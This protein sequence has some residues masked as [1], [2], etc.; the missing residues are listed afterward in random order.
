[1]IALVAQWIEHLTTD[2]KVVGSTPAERASQF[3]GFEEVAQIAH[4]TSQ[5]DSPRQSLA[6]NKS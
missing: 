3:D 4:A 2:Q 1:M 5:P 6:A